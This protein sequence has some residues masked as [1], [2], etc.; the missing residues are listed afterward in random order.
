LKFDANALRLLAPSTHF[1][2][3]LLNRLGAGLNIFFVFFDG[4]TDV[5]NAVAERLP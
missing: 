3:K 2:A 5:K 1:A 4:I